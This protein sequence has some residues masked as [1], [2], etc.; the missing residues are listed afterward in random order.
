MNYREVNLPN[1]QYRMLRG[2]V[3]MLAF[4]PHNGTMAEIGCYSGDSAVVWCSKAAT[5][6][7]IDP[8]SW[9]PEY[10]AVPCEQV[11]AAF[12]VKVLN[13]F[14]AVAVKWKMTSAEAAAKMA[15]GSLDAV[16]IDGRH[17]YEYVAHDLRLWVPKVKIGG[18][19]M[20]HDYTNPITPGVK[21]AVDEFFGAPDHVFC[22]WSFAKRRLA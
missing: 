4:I 6:Y 21:R 9:T 14:P 18:W 17:E 8:W 3:D 1:D 16:Y 15:D 22:D 7:C 2:L 11:E 19:V 12:D 5:L 10:H 13:R 20:G